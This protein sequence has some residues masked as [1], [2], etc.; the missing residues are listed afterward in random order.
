M[1]RRISS[2]WQWQEEYQTNVGQSYVLDDKS[3]VSMEDENSIGR[4]VA[5]A[6]HEHWGW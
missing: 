3:M 5:K 6:F 1:R 2:F 4:D